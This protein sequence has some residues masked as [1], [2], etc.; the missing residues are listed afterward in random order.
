MSETI[1][2]EWFAKCTNEAAGL[3]PHPILTAVPICWSCASKMDVTE[4]VKPF[5]V[6]EACEVPGG[7]HSG[8]LVAVYYGRLTPRTLC[9]FHALSVNISDSLNSWE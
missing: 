2:C 6:A 4:Q 5:P 8:D 1:T 3:A 7:H 9:G